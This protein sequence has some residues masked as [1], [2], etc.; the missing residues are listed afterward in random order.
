MLLLCSKRTRRLSIT[1][2]ACRDE[3]EQG[4]KDRYAEADH[5]VEPDAQTAS[6][7]RVADRR[8]DLIPGRSVS[9]QWAEDGALFGSLTCRRRGF[10]PWRLTADRRLG[11]LSGIEIIGKSDAKVR[12][13]MG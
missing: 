5:F 8:A 13:G 3:H 4:G 7:G 6:V 9:D 1:L 2:M 12:E 11:P 10:R